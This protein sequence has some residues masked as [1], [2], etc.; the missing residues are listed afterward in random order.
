MCRNGRR[1]RRRSVADGKGNMRTGGTTSRNATNI[2]ATT[3]SAADDSVDLFVLVLS[4]FFLH[5]GG[6]IKSLEGIRS[7]D[8]GDLFEG[9]DDG[10]EIGSLFWISIPTL[11]DETLKETVLRYWRSQILVAC[12][13]NRFEGGKIFVRY[14]SC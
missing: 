14:S 2:S 11:N 10:V 4:F 1:R 13:S 9:L 3:K 5:I 8:V 7:N 6:S 12:S